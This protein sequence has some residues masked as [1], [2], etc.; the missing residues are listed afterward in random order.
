MHIP[1]IRWFARRSVAAAMGIGVMMSFASSPA[2]SA[3]PSAWTYI[4]YSDASHTEEVGQ[5]Y[6]GC[7]SCGTVI[8]TQTPY[9]DIVDV[10][11]CS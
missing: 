4:Y 11:S 5:R 3:R 7:Q 8:G 9:Y 6:C 2:L 1:S 10:M